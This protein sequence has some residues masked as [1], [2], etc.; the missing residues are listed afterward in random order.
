VAAPDPQ[1]S[2][3]VAGIVTGPDGAPVRDAF[4]SLQ[5]PATTAS[6]RTDAAGA[7]TITG[8]SPGTYA[9]RVSAVGYNPL[10][11]RPI[12]VRA[13]QTTQTSL[14][15]ARSSSS[16]GTIGRVQSNGGDAVSTSATPVTTINPQT[17]AAEGY[18]RVSDV[19]QDDIST[20][21]VHAA[22]GGSTAL[23]TSV[24]LRG[25]D[26][27]ETLVD[28]DGHQVNSGA[29][30]DFDLSLLDPADY[31]NIEL[32]KGISP[33]SLVGPDTIDGAI[34]LR[35]IEPTITPH[36]L[37]RLSA[38]SFNSFAETIQATGT[39]GRLGYAISLHKTTTDG[40]V[41]QTVFDANTNQVAQVGSGVD[42]STALG[43]LRYAF[44]ANGGGYAEFSF[45]DQSATRDISAALSSYPSPE[46]TGPPDLT[47]VDGFEGSSIAS[48]NA[49]YGLDLRI[50]IGGTDAQGTEPASILFRHYTSYVSQSVFGSAAETSPYLYN[51]RD[52]IGENSLE[53]DKQFSNGSLTLQYSIRNE[54]LT[55]T[56]GDNGGDINLES[57]A[58][59]TP[60]TASLERF[61]FPDGY[62]TDAEESGNASTQAV[63]VG[64][65][66]GNNTLLS[67]TQ[68]AAVLRYIYDPTPKLHLIAA[69]YY[70]DYS[71]FGRETD[72]RF[73]FVYTPD[74][75]SAVRFSVGS[76]YQSPQLPEL[77]TPAVLP[78]PVAGIITTGNPNLQPD[79]ATE[80]GLGLTHVFDTGPHRTDVGIDLYRVNLRSPASTYVPAGNADSS[81]GSVASGGDGTPCLLSYAINAGDGVY[82]GIEITGQRR[83]A[84]FTTL[85]AGWA[86]RSNYLTSIPPYIQDGT[87]VLGEQG[88][89]TPLQKA[90][91]G[92][93]V[94]PPRGLSFRTELVYDG[95]YNELFQPPFV[96]VAAAVGYRWPTY[97]VVLAG[98][99]L[100]NV[101][102]QR[103]IN[104]NGGVPYGIIGALQP[105]DSYPLQ[106]AAFNIS[107]ARRF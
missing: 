6:A 21:L 72:P 87:L 45:H 56:D 28:I 67:Q 89:G 71:I 44:G 84:P 65:T 18:T 7:F 15:L 102:D 94:A 22:G 75:R 62:A 70:S 35:T 33:S 1:S 25:P 81:C 64:E 9:I 20:S 13:S 41:N 107:V 82:Q 61:A 101:Y 10:A 86:V 16:L 103:F 8:L 96:T 31:S 73:G 83:L 95:S 78:P 53:F 60:N 106:G 26:P 40:E 51:D 49:G 68:R 23:P 47:V 63:S 34:N 54:N 85:N 58:R 38:G 88:Q 30:G 57:V 55:I 11:P 12:G 99:N 46:V 59:Q 27:T 3:G 4:V 5:G 76:T 66:V 36:G 52:L 79:H 14:G 69:A 90:T 77:Y 39:E 104:T 19:L 98:T 105:S 50:P 24:A 97:E 93:T 42:G 17:F 91:L 43:K 100:T 2:G 29:T 48:H 92:L 32:V 74:S 80:Y 37:L